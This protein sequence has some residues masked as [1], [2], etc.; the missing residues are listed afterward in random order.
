MTIRKCKEHIYTYETCRERNEKSLEF[1][2]YIIGE[3]DLGAFPIKEL[4]GC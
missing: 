4:E 3:L 2:K 1:C